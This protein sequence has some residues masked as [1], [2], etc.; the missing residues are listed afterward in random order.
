MRDEPHRRLF[1]EHQPKRLAT[2]NYDVPNFCNADGTEDV[3]LR[4][5]FMK[6]LG[7]VVLWEQQL[8]YEIDTQYENTPPI[9]YAR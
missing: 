6:R 8:R 1:H 4:D 7:A 5:L 9:K 3:E 2:G